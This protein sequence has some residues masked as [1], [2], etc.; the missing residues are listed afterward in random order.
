MSNLKRIVVALLACTIFATHAADESGWRKLP[1]IENGKVA[2]D[3]V[4]IGFG[5][6]AIDGDALRTEPAPEGLGLLV[7]KKEKLGNCQLKVLFK[8][9]DQRAN[10]GVYVRIADGILDQV[11]K[12]GHPFTRDAKGTPTDESMEKAQ[13]AADREEGPW[14]AV[15]RGY[16]VQ[17]AGGGDRFHRTGSIY[18]LA[19]SEEG[20]KGPGEWQTMI[21]TL[22]GTKISV[23]LD[24]KKVSSLDT[25]SKDLPE[26]KQW[27]EPKR[28]PKRPEVGYIGLQTH[29][30]G[31]VVW[32]REVSVK[33]LAK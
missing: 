2:P 12:P 27:H 15:H 22:D 1:L 21:I 33:P 6:M 20:P 25:A 10:A 24:G 29:D 4:H 32:F 7:Y 18:S 19:P 23:E 3:W 9:K 13:A 31:D 28:E 26:R 8:T 30:P 16:E 5:H 17:I 14:F 11:K